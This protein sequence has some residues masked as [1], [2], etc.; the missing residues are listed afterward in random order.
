[1]GQHWLDDFCLPVLLLCSNFLV[2]MVWCHPEFLTL[3]YGVSRLRR[4]LAQEVSDARLQNDA[5]D[6]GRYALQVKD[7]LTLSI[8]A[9]C[10]TGG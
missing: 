9:L 6:E 2:I 1:M 3:S 8:K 5:L 10:H 4:R 7:L